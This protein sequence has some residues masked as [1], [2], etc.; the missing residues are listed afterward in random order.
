MSASGT[1]STRVLSINEPSSNLSQFTD[2]VLTSNS[3][4]QAVM[5]DSASSNWVNKN[6][7]LDDLSDMNLNL[8]AHDDVL[9]WNSSLNQWENGKLTSLLTTLAQVVNGIV[10]IQL[11]VFIGERGDSAQSL[12]V[13]FT[14]S[15]E[16]GQTLGMASCGDNNAIY[17]KEPSDPDF[18]F[19]TTLNRG[20]IYQDNLP[21]GTVFR[22]EKGLTGCTD[23]FP[24]PFGVSCLADTY[25]RFYAFRQNVLVYA[26]SAGRDSLVT[27]YASDETT[28]V[29]GPTFISAYGSVTLACDVSASEFVVVSTTDIF[30]G[31]GSYNTNPDNAAT[32]VRLIPPMRTELIV[33][34]RGNRV[35]AQF[36]DT[37]VTWYKRDMTQGTVTVNGG[38]PFTIGNVANAG[39][40]NWFQNQGWLILR[41]D[42]P[43]S[44]FTGADGAGGNATE[45]WPLEFLAQNFPIYSTISTDP[46]FHQAGINIASPYEGEAR[47]Y[48]STGALVFTFPYVRGTS[49][50]VTPDDQQYPAAGQS[51]PGS[52]GYAE[53]TGGWI[54]TTSPAVCVINFI[55]TATGNFGVSDNGDE[56]VIPG[57]SPEE[58]KAQIR[59]D[60]DGFLRRRDIDVS[61]V[62]TWNIC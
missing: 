57:T 38:T 55:G 33:H 8:V 47:V 7:S 16:N 26:T 3:H 15:V 18:T 48:D 40:D 9:I 32:D 24:T 27:L 5:Y 14:D 44:S 41:S 4:D 21:A 35:T 12:C 31:T 59:K 17:K 19:L 36:S 43:I 13:A 25:F 29:D 52:D 23:P 37:S 6:I 22:S 28:I 45:A 56:T 42:K 34:N 54:E 58:L 2:V 39:N 49:P 10:S 46:D 62:E 53:L 20:E 50:P 11:S 60:P 51:N 61:G 30:C 1:V